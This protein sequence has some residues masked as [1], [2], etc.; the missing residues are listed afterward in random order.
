M[1]I[2]SEVPAVRLPSEQRRGSAELVSRGGGHGG[3]DFGNV[4][5]RP[6]GSSAALEDSVDSWA[7]APPSTGAAGLQR[8]RIGVPVTN[9]HRL[10]W[11]AHGDQEATETALGD[12]PRPLLPAQP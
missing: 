11:A 2:S 1:S 8:R 3:E 10:K 9:Q 4:T 5:R 12:S 7:T 6:L